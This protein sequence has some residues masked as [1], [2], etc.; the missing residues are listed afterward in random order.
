MSNPRKIP[1][2]LQHTPIVCLSNYDQIDGRY[3]GPDDDVKF[4][5]IGLAQWDE[6][7]KAQP[8]S[9][10]ALRHTG[11]QWSP[12]SEEVPIH[13]CLDMCSFIAEVFSTI[14]SNDPRTALKNLSGERFEDDSAIEVPE[15]TE[16]NGYYINAILKYISSD[17]NYLL[18]KA[19]HLQKVL[20]KFIDLLKNI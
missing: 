15:W 17:K 3:S 8:I 13:R 20:P 14:M 11:K 6:T 19:E 2:G 18:P 7:S 5:S 10:K 4:L 9:C 1:E 16:D 12:Q